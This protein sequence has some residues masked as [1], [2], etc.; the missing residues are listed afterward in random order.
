MIGQELMQCNVQKGNISK[1]LESGII[2]LRAAG[3]IEMR[4]T[5]IRT[6]QTCQQ[7]SYLLKTGQALIT[8][9]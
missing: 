8:I 2:L 4:C 1:W 6:N 3:L 5:C 7:K 9:N